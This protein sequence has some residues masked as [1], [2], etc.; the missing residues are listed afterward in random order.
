MFLI[1]VLDLDCVSFG[2]HWDMHTTC[3]LRTCVTSPRQEIV[4]QK[5]RRVNKCFNPTFFNFTSP[6]RCRSL[7]FSATNSFLDVSRME[8]CRTGPGAG[9]YQAQPRLGP[10]AHEGGKPSIHS[11]TSQQLKNLFTYQLE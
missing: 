4:F 7:D 1:S 9:P 2:I 3:V 10:Q 5:S 8:L 11:S 6:L